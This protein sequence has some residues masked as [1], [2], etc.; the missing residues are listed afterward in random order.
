MTKASQFAKWSAIATLVLAALYLALLYL[1][2]RY[3]DGSGNP[4]VL[5][6]VF[7]GVGLLA[8]FSPMVCIVAFILNRTQKRSKD[9][10]AA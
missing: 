9:D 4:S 5:L 3:D 7:M 6:F 8:Y 2:D 1:L 10:P